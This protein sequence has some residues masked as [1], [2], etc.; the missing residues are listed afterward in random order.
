MSL[1]RS[2]QLQVLRNESAAPEKEPWEKYLLPNPHTDRLKFYNSIV[3]QIYESSFVSKQAGF[4]QYLLEQ[5]QMCW[6]LNIK[7]KALSDKET[8]LLRNEKWGV[9]QN[10]NKF[11]SGVDGCKGSD[12]VAKCESCL[13]T[14]NDAFNSAADLLSFI[15]NKRKNLFTEEHNLKPF[16]SDELK[17]FQEAQE[18]VKAIYE[19][20]QKASNT[21]TTTF[22]SLK[23]KFPS[24]MGNNRQSRRKKENKR[25]VKKTKE[26]RLHQRAYMLLEKLT[27]KEV[28]DEIFDSLENN[29]NFTSVSS[30]NAEFTGK[31]VRRLHL[32]PLLWLMEK[33][34]FDTDLARNMEVVVA[35]MN[36]GNGNGDGKGSGS[37]EDSDESD[38]E[39]VQ[40]PVEKAA[41]ESA[42]EALGG[43][44]SESVS[45]E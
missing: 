6:Q 7:I 1:G 8:N 45:P 22:M 36:E 24:R 30:I 17:Y 16:A 3:Q 11:I 35:S 42:R 5:Q 43:Q 31:F 15:D 26:K 37:G 14:V 27:S 23:R 28:T 10:I 12:D 44:D 33:G 38:E 13:T 41:E 40:E 25:K 18:R 21:L 9:C 32:D 19:E 4:K 39:A 20:L 34:V 29:R 2:G